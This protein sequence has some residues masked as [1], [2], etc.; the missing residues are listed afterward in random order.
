[1]DTCVYDLLFNGD[2]NL[3]D[4]LLNI[5]HLAFV[6]CQTLYEL[7]A[8][9]KQLL[10]FENVRLHNSQQQVEQ[11]VATEGG[12]FKLTEGNADNVKGLLN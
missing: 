10:S 12:Y 6:K 9:E 3:F 5:F 2:A 8:N 11:Q 4:I 1:M 7:D